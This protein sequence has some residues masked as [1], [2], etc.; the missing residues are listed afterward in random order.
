AAGRL[1][2]FCH[3]LAATEN[4]FLREPLNERANDFLIATETLRKFI[5]YKFFVFPSK[6][7]GEDFRFCMTPALNCDREGDGSLGQMRKY[8]VLTEELNELIRQSRKLYSDLRVTVKREL[9]V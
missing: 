1:D 8:D 2:N 7:S 9:V 6:Q 3:V 5:S 4:R